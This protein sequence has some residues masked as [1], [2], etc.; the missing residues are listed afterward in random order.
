MRGRHRDQRAATRGTHSPAELCPEEA[1]PEEGWQTRAIDLVRSAYQ[2]IG[3]DGFAGPNP[4]N[5]RVT[6]RVAWL[7][8]APIKGLA[9]QERESVEL[10]AYGVEDD[11]RFCI[12]EDGGNVLNAK[13]VP[14]FVRIRPTLDQAGQRLDLGMPDGARISGEIALGDQ[15]EMSMYGGR[16]P[17]R[18]V[19]GPWSEALSAEAG[20][21]V[22]LVRLDRPG[23]GVDRAE[24]GAGATLLGA[25][26]LRAIARAAGVSS[27]VD[28]RRFRMLIGVRGIEAHA[29][30]EWIGRPVRVG[31]AV[32][33]PSGNVGRCAV[34]TIDPVSGIMDL[35]TLKALARYRGAV[36][37]SERLPFGVWA[38]IERP[39]RISL[40]D[41]VVPA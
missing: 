37:T 2:E 12:V 13:R 28:P 24:H 33:V 22:R 21:P 40:G 18:E 27:P 36:E 34:T 5:A 10:H 20:R 29:E 23:E 39:G 38:R 1:G 41:E 3:L 15:L 19:L 11:R 7:H 4:D 8:V 25:E 6:A 9:I 32:V 14:G 17:A 31:E 30:D 16:S 26:S 35:D